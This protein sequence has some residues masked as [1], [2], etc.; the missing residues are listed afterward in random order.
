[1]KLNLSKIA[2]ASAAAAV[3]A[4]MAVTPVFAQ[5]TPT[6]PT[7]A[8]RTMITIIIESATATFTFHVS[9]E[10]AAELAAELAAETATE[11]EVDEDAEVEQEDA[12]PLKTAHVEKHAVVVKTTDPVEHESD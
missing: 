4:I 11:T 9:A 2:S 12:A 1:M 5:T 6:T 10:K 8:G 3:G 7:P